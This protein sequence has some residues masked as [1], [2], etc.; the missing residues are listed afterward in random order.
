MT[1]T[2]DEEI[3]RLRTY[4]KRIRKEEPGSYMAML[5]SDGLL[6]WFEAQLR[7]DVDCKALVK[8]VAL[9]LQV[10]EVVVEA[11]RPLREEIAGLKKLARIAEVGA[12]CKAREYEHARDDAEHWRLRYEE[13]QDHYHIAEAQINELQ[14]ELLDVKAAGFDLYYQLQAALHIR[15][16]TFS[17]E[18]LLREMA[19][20]GLQP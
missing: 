9:G 12:E 7:D 6:E 11:E 15:F 20:R 10:E 16:A 4:A 19:A 3:H 2:K 18:D 13:V 17:D 14:H 8:L 5:L 1:M